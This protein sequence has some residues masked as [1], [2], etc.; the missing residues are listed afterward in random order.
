M[1]NSVMLIAVL[2]ANVA[3]SITLSLL[4]PYCSIHDSSVGVSMTHARLFESFATLG[5]CAKASSTHLWTQFWLNV[6]TIAS[7]LYTYVL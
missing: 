7:A 6:Y 4:H 3:N 5:I 2:V 1:M